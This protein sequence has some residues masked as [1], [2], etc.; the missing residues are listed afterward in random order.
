[1]RLAC[2]EFP[3]FQQPVKHIR[4]VSVVLISP[5][6]HLNLPKDPYFALNLGELLSW[7]LAAW[8][9]WLVL[10]V[11]YFD[12]YLNAQCSVFLHQPL[13]LS[14][15]IHT[16]LYRHSLEE[17]SSQAWTESEGPMRGDEGSSCT[18]VL[19]TNLKLVLEDDSEMQSTTASVSQW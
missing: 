1:M 7:L 15:Q 9:L 16:D 13:Y 11:K 3:G 14:G 5:W 8:S 10:W 4:F 2:R 17:F 18:A 6:S 19:H 12:T